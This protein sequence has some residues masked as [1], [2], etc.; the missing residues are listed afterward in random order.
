[1]AINK[2]INKSSK[3]HGAMRNCLEYVLR[4]EKT[5]ERLTYVTGPYSYNEI[6]WENVYKSFVEEKKLWNKDSGRM[7]N[8]NIISFPPN[9]DIT[10]EQA[11]EFGKEFAETWFPE[12]QSLIAVHQDR[13][14]IHM[15]IVTNTVSY[16]DGQKL[17]NTKQD[18]QRMKEYTN[19]M[20]RERGLSIAEKGRH[21]DGSAIEAGTIIAWSKDVYHMLADNGVKSAVV[22][23]FR[24][25][26]QSV[27]TS[28]SKEDFIDKMNSQG[29][30]V[31]WDEKHKYITFINSEG[32]RVRD[33]MISKTFNVDISKNSLTRKFEH[34]NLRID[35]SRRM[36]MY[37]EISNYR[38][39]HTYHR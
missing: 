27:D 13:D 7:Y 28:C 30:T 22:D 26:Q 14:H 24:S 29:W 8:H 36:E 20:C 37:S 34:D 1:M 39:H 9:E 35:Y 17:H 10:V 25:L 4:R 21:Y 11:L 5:E 32:F 2:T 19:S 16:V 12:H 3:S 38:Q 31:N 6:T 15:H 33:S 18:L 23:C